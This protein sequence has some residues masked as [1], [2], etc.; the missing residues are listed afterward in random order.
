MWV[1]ESRLY[2]IL[3]RGIPQCYELPSITTFPMVLYPIFDCFLKCSG[4]YSP[5]CHVRLHIQSTLDN[6][7]LEENR[8]KVRVIGS[9]SNRE[10]RFRLV[11][12]WFSYH[13]LSN[14][15]FKSESSPVELMQKR[16]HILSNLF[17]DNNLGKQIIYLIIHKILKI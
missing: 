11:F 16:Q 14:F 10:A 1:L 17:E 2:T 5:I 7:N 15:F 9:L 12:F 6:S 13:V 3:K 4:I 8:K